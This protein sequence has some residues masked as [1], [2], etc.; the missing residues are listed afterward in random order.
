M[1]A[2]P[3]RLRRPDWPLLIASLVIAIAIV[4]IGVAVS[5]AVTGDE[6][7]NLPAAI[8]E[9]NPIRGATQVPS[10]TDVFVDLLPGYEGVLV[11]DGLELETISRDE[12]QSEP[13]Q[14]VSLPPTTI[15]D[16]GNATLTFSPS[17]EAPITEFTQGQHIVQVIYWKTI[18]GRGT[19]RSYT[20]SF[21]I[22]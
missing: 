14:Q 13:G 8:E 9:I 20:W 4:A 18:E 19:A 15:Y 10:Q 11:I 17:D 16:P 22:L 1:A 5:I 2:V 7:Q 12:L 3:F 21:E 6:G